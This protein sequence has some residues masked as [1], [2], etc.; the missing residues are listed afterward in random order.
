MLRIICVRGQH[1][2]AY[3]NGQFIVSADNLK[4]LYSELRGLNYSL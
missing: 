2:E 4:E 1:Y 3:W